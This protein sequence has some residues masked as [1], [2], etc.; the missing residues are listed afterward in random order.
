MKFTCTILRPKMYRQ[1]RRPAMCAYGPNKTPPRHRPQKS[2]GYTM[3]LIV[4]WGTIW[5]ARCSWLKKAA[6]MLGLR[7]QQG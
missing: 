4:P 2:G 1:L 3:C 7:D 5:T 6:K